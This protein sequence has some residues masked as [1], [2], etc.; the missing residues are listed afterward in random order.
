MGD[1]GFLLYAAA[2]KVLICLVVVNTIAILTLFYFTHKI[3]KYINRYPAFFCLGS[4][5][6]SFLGSVLG[7][8]LS[9]ILYIII[10]SNNAVIHCIAVSNLVSI[11]YLLPLGNI[12][13]TSPTFVVLFLIIY[14]KNSH[15]STMPSSKARSFI[16]SFLFFNILCFIMSCLIRMT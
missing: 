3:R 9:S 2:I 13:F 6:G 16:F 5:L 4:I 15:S 10:S 11:F 14:Y 1:W 12:I 7:G 8:S